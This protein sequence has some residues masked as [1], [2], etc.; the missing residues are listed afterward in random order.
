M[1]KE[2]KLTPLKAIKL[3]CLD[4]SNYQLKEIRKCNIVECSLYKFRFGRKTK[5]NKNNSNK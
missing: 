5:N 2:T 1:K 3:K 4:C